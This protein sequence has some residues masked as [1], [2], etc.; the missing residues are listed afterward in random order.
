MDSLIMACVL[1]PYLYLYRQQKWPNGRIRYIVLGL[2]LLCNLV[3]NA[4]P[5]G[6]KLKVNWHEK[7]HLMNVVH[8]MSKM[9][10]AGPKGLHYIDNYLLSNNQIHVAYHI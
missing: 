3:I 10:S 4:V 7:S 8:T 5:S 1:S 2:C 9:R 6:T